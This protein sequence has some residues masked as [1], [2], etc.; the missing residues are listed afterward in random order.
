MKRA[1][2]TYLAGRRLVV[3]SPGPRAARRFGRR[4]RG[5]EEAALESDQQA[6]AG[7]PVFGP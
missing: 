6:Q 7:I 1:G 3:V 4:R 2:W 5:G